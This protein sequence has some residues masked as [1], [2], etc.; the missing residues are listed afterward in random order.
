MPSD[1]RDGSHETVEGFGVGKV[2][3][4]IEVSFAVALAIG[5]RRK[6]AI[7]FATAR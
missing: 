6:A 5:L 2:D 1:L 7:R 4:A 3:E